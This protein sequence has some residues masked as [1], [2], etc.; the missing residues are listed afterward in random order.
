MP[1]TTSIEVLYI[2]DDRDE[3][4]LVS[5]ALERANDVLTVRTASGAADGLSHLANHDI[6]CIVSEYDLPET[7]GLALFAD[8]ANDDPALPFLIF[9]RNED[10]NVAREVL[11]AG[12]TDYLRKQTIEKDYAVLADRIIT[13][14]E[15]PRSQVGGQERK[16]QKTP[17]VEECDDATS[18]AHDGDRV[19]AIHG[20]ARHVKDATDMAAVG[21]IVVDAAETVLGLNRS[22]V[23]LFNESRD[24]LEPLALSQDVKTLFDGTPVLT[25]DDGLFREVYER[26]A[27]HIA[28]IDSTETPTDPVQWARTAYLYP[29]GR[30]GVLITSADEYTED[31]RTLLESVGLLAATAESALERIEREQVLEGLQRT[32]RRLME[33]STKREVCV[34]AAETARTVLN[35]PLMGLWLYDEEKDALA[36]VAQTKESDELVDE[37]PTYS[38]GTSLSWKVFATGEPQVYDDLR[39]ESNVYNAATKIRSEIILP[40]GE[41]GVLNIGSTTPRTFDDIDVYFAE[42]LAANTTAALERVERVKARSR[43]QKALRESNQKIERLHEV[44]TRMVTCETKQA[45]CELTVDAAERILDFDICV[46]DLES[47]GI[48]ETRAISSNIPLEN[49][50][51]MSIDEGIAGKTYRTGM[52]QLTDDI[53]EVEEANTSGE[54]RSG[55]SVPI[56]N[57]GVFQAVAEEVGFFSSDDVELA[58]LLVLHSSEA[59]ARIEREQT[60][61]ER[62]EELTRQRDQLE[63]FTG[64]VSHDLRNPLNVATGYLD[65]LK[66]TGDDS[67]FEKVEHAHSRLE[68]ILED[69]LTLAQQG[70]VVDDPKPVR[71]DTVAQQAWENV[72]TAEATLDVNCDCTILA[73][74]SRFQQLLENLFSN[75]VRHGGHD[76]TVRVGTI[77]TGLF[78]EDTGPGIPLA[79]RDCVFD[80]DY[81][82]ADD[83]TGFGLAIVDQIVDA[84]DWEVTITSGGDDGARFEITNVEEVSLPEK[85]E[86]AS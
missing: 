29:L 21:T 83:G 19:A 64:I 70:R 85:C 69:V 2:D 9:T 7:D 75:A 73:D 51:N 26:Q 50:A 6:D 1:G 37:L 30:H 18:H 13:A 5:T 36:P 63:N 84:H 45:V 44:A 33:V 40:L 41:K 22:G 54:Y 55:I 58:E 38:E 61:H 8:V 56:G 60:L 80:S 15:Q 17:V 28:A 12:V 57:Y 82:T 24:V 81:T 78:I 52:S 20:V 49:T 47:N 25:D 77:S 14:V 31:E 71:C 66:E 43:A 74:E 42:M 16:L 4:T 67:Y 79:D 27:P 62:T 32:G 72:E 46:V 10:R 35:L 3:S 11:A 65:I 86:D 68:N 59:L 39:D 53:R 34:I 76:V 48:L 23:Y